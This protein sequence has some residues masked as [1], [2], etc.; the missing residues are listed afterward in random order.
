MAINLGKE[1]YRIY[2][3]ENKKKTRPSRRNFSSQG[4]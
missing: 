1:T 2:N 4:H 3:G